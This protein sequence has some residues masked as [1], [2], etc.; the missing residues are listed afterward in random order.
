MNYL[1]YDRIFLLRVYE[2]NEIRKRFFR[3]KNVKSKKECLCNFF[4]LINKY[5]TIVLD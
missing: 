3:I 2:V 4:S 1:R 5:Q